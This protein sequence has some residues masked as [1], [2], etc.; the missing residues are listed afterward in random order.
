MNTLVWLKAEEKQGTVL[1]LTGNDLYKLE[2]SGKDAGRAA[3]EAAAALGAGGSPSGVPAKSSTSLPLASIK[4]LHTS[5]NHASLKF[6]G[7][8]DGQPATVSFLAK[9]NEEGAAIGRAVAERAGITEPE[10]NE[11]VSVVEALTGPVILGVI[12]GVLWLIVYVVAAGIE[13]GEEIKTDQ[14]SS[15]GR[16][17]K[18]LVYF[19]ASILGVKGSIAVGVVLLLL[20]GFWGYTVVAKRPQRIAWGAPSA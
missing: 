7:A 14:G 11:D 18:K 2:F 1:A 6:H 10:R 13:N 3:V 9:S 15:R 4:R 17:M 8:A 20:F 5:S 16:G 12:A 19:V